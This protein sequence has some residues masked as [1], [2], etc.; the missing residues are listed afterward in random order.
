MDRFFSNNLSNA[1]FPFSVIKGL[2]TKMSEWSCRL[3]NKWRFKTLQCLSLSPIF[4]R[5]SD[6][7]LGK[8]QTS[9]NAVALIVFGFSWF[10]LMWMVC[11]EGS[12]PRAES[13]MLQSKSWAC[14]R[15]PSTARVGIKPRIWKDSSFWQRRNKSAAKPISAGSSTWSSST[16]IAKCLRLLAH[17]GICNK[18]RNRMRLSSVMEPRM[19]ISSKFFNE[20]TP[21]IKLSRS[22]SSKWFRKDHSIST[23]C[24]VSFMGS[25]PSTKYMASF[26]KFS[27]DVTPMRLLH[28]T[29]KVAPVP[30]SDWLYSDKRWQPGWFSERFFQMTSMVSKSSKWKE[31]RQQIQEPIRRWSCVLRR[32]VDLSG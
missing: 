16:S 14:A 1:L 29:A 11:K 2:S 24:R 22:S 32:R 28:L 3:E 30:G 19:E 25:T 31:W 26:K 20:A 27:S 13:K 15:T 8:I 10:R 4:M 9:R 5:E 6:C 7:S 18:L 23:V 21:R 17:S 12:L